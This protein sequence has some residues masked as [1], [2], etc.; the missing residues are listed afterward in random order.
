MHYVVLLADLVALGLAATA[1]FHTLYLARIAPKARLRHAWLAM[2]GLLAVVIMLGTYSTL[3]RL[4]SHAFNSTVLIDCM[5]NLLGAAIIFAAILLSRLTA[6][7]V[8]KVAELERAAYTDKLTGLPNRRSFD[9]GLSTQVE[10]ARRR[11]QPLVLLMLDIDRFKRVND[12]NGHACGD[13]VLAHLG[14]ILATYERRGDTAFRIGGEEFAVLAPHTGI[15]QG[16]AAA[17]RLR[18]AIENTPLVG[19]EPPIAVTVSFGV[20]A[21][22]KDDDGASLAKR[23]DEAL[24]LAKRTGRNR[25]CTEDDLVAPSPTAAHP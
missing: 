2:T 10:I 14:R 19:E 15:A 18:L 8:L 9:L 25:V 6:D 12:E 13:R 21:L 24:Y 5:I 20:A 1:C 7:D 11:K 3:D 23:A 17:E 16:R 22:H 4:L